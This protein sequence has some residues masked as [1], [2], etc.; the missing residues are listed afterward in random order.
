M[1]CNFVTGFNQE[2]T[3]KIPQKGEKTVKTGVDKNLQKTP[4]GD[5]RDVVSDTDSCPKSS[6]L[7]ETE[8]NYSNTENQ[9]TEKQ[10]LVVTF[11]DK[12]FAK[13]EKFG[14]KQYHSKTEPCPILFDQKDSRSNKR[15]FDKRTPKPQPNKKT[16]QNIEGKKSTCFI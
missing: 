11:E 16:G 13:N 10:T 8:N 5:F 15:M 4:I 7:S 6:E 2:K 9:R 1:Q 12:I 3:S 14:E